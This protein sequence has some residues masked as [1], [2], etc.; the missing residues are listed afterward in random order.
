MFC[1]FGGDE[2]P[3]CGYTDRRHSFVAI[4]GLRTSLW[5][6]LCLSHIVID[7]FHAHL[8]AHIVDSLSVTGLAVLASVSPERPR[9]GRRPR[10]HRPS[11][12]HGCPLFTGSS[13]HRSAA[14]AAASSRPW[15]PPT[16][17]PPPPLSGTVAGRT[18]TVDGGWTREGRGQRAQRSPPGQLGIGGMRG[19]VER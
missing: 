7:D 11:G 6:S 16:C 13:G 15:V 3:A 8:S 10:A 19:N 14:A 1:D 9:P 4:Y 5:Q 17:S 2:V 12:R 18:G